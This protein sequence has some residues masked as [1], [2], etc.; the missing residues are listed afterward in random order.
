MNE[1]LSSQFFEELAVGRREGMFCINNIVCE[2]YG[3]NDP[4]FVEEAPADRQT[5]LALSNS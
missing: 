1:S 5:N 4:R 3:E 2:K